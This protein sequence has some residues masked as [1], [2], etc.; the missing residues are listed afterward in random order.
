MLLLK[1]KA[2][3]SKNNYGTML[4]VSKHV[5]LPKISF[6]LCKME[7]EKQCLFFNLNNSSAMKIIL[8]KR[9]SDG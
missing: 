4:L 2:Q 9:A 7:C 1:N 5:S 8:A 3:F 6:F